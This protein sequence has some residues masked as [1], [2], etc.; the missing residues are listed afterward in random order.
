MDNKA[1]LDQIAVKDTKKTQSS[2]LLSPALLKL[3][4][5]AL[6]LIVVLIAMI[7]IFSGQNKNNN[8]SYAELYQRYEKLLAEDSPMITQKENLHS[9]ALRANTANFLSLARSFKTTYTNATTSTG[10][11]IYTLAPE[12]YS[13]IEQEFSDFGTNLNNAYMNGYLDQSYA[14]ECAYQVAILIQLEEDIYNTANNDALREILKSNIEN[15]RT[16]QAIY[17]KYDTE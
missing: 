7:S 1:Y 5:G 8:S 2:P 14:S 3:I 15:L 10:L 16:F 12:K 11:D 17:E 6:F 4:I 9:S 13:T